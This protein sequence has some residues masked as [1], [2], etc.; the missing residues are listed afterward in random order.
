MENVINLHQPQPPGTGQAFE[1]GGSRLVGALFFLQGGDAL[2]RSVGS[3]LTVARR[4]EVGEAKEVGKIPGDGRGNGGEVR[5]SPS[6][7]KA[8]LK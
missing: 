8:K 1:D 4:D 5:T 3:V 6:G 7:T 2:I